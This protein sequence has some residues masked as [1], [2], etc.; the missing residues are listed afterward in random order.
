MKSQMKQCACVK[1]KNL[2][3]EVLMYEAPE[4]NHILYAIL[5][6][7]FFPLAIFWFLKVQSVKKDTES[8]LNIAL[9]NLKCEKC[10]GQLMVVSH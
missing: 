5:T 1:C 7:L 8:N 3:N 10:G 9:S 2:Q 4:V 6:V